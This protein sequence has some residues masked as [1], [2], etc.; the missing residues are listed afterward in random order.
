MKIMCKSQKQEAG[1]FDEVNS[2]AFGCMA[3]QKA[4]CAHLRLI[5]A[6][7]EPVLKQ[8]HHRLWLIPNEA[9][10]EPLQQLRICL[11]RCRQER[12][13]TARIS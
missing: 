2:N 9:I 7:K 5:K 10:P 12:L 11:Q 3:W 13:Y 8:V 4:I 1:L 6:H